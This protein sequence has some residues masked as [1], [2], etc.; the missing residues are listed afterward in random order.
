MPK[1]GETSR[2]IGVL[3]KRAEESGLE[4][5]IVREGNAHESFI[6]RDPN[7]GETVV[8]VVSNGGL[9]DKEI[10]ARILRFLKRLATSVT[11]ATIVHKVMQ[12]V[13]GGK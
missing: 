1:E 2:I 9:N 13:F 6:I 7:T 11:I 8:L 10:Q 5:T 4:C 3:R 12:H